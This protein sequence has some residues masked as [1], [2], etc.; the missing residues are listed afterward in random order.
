MDLGENTFGHLKTN[1]S[2]PSDVINQMENES[3]KDSQIK[4]K[5]LLEDQNKENVTKEEHNVNGKDETYMKYED[6]YMCTEK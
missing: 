3:K 4:K 6:I 5:E 2:E 1:I